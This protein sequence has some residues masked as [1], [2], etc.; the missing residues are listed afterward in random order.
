MRIKTLAGIFVAG[1][2]VACTS[3]DLP[4]PTTVEQFKAEIKP[5]MT[6]G[7][8]AKIAGPPKQRFPFANDLDPGF[9]VYE[10]GGK[11]VWIIYDLNEVVREVRD[12]QR[13][14]NGLK[15]PK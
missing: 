12:K 11:Q 3:P 4:R 7:D 10:Y 1:L 6:L 14:E 8:V 15:I 5:G 9:C 2:A 13:V